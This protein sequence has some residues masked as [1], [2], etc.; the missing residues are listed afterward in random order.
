MRLNVIY[1]NRDGYGDDLFI[2][3]RHGKKPINEARIKTRGRNDDEITNAKIRFISDFCNQHPD[4]LAKDVLRAFGAKDEI[5][6]KIYKTQY[7]QGGYRG[8]GRRKGTERTETLNQR[9]TKDEKEF[10]LNALAALRNNPA[11]GEILQQ[12]KVTAKELEF[13]IDALDRYRKRHVLIDAMQGGKN[14]I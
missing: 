8:G 12:E 6:Q 10:L 4:I 5:I 1:E 13:L 14:G 3:I 7:P 11:F 9:I 2:V